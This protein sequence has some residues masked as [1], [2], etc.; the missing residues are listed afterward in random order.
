MNNFEG[1]DTY[2]ILKERI[3]EL[4]QLRDISEQEYYRAKLSASTKWE[5][6][7]AVLMKEI[8]YLK[9]WQRFLE[10]QMPVNTDLKELNN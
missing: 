10:K 7:Q 1:L 4:Y 8:S 6:K 3:K 2:D 5:T 9:D